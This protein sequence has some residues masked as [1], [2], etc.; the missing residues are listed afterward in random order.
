MG[1]G[2]EAVVGWAGKAI[3]FSGSFSPSR[4]ASRLD[5]RTIKLELT[6]DRSAGGDLAL[7]SAL[8]FASRYL[9]RI[10][11]MGPLDSSLFSLPESKLPY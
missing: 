7:L 4:L 11:P 6:I 9:L 1:S 8:S 2:A 3:C 10:H 5:P